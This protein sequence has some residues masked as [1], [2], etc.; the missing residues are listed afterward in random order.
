MEVNYFCHI[1]LHVNFKYILFIGITGVADKLKVNLDI[2]LVP[3]DFEERSLCFG[4]NF[5][6]PTK[7]TPF[8]TLFIGALDDFMLK[9]LLACAVISISFD[10][11]FSD[12]SRK[13]GN[14]SYF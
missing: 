3:T 4:C 5:K 14:I 2:G 12:H 8:C 6:E 11:G 10:M 13:T 9:L 1:H 7:R